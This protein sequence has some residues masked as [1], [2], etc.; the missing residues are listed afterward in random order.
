MDAQT[1]ELAKMA[2]SSAAQG[3]G[4]GLRPGEAALAKSRSLAEP[5]WIKP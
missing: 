5:G 3:L 1:Y 2:V 4:I